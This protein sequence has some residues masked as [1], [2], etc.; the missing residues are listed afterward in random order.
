MINEVNWHQKMDSS[1]VV[2]VV[3]TYN[4]ADNLTTLVERLN[5]VFESNKL[6]ARILVVDDSS[7]DGTAEIARKLSKNY[8]VDLLVRKKKEGLGRAYIAGF[9][10]A[11]EMGADYIF[12]MDADLSHDPKYVPDFME[13]IKTFD[14]VVGNRYIEGGETVDWPFH[15][16]L[17]SKSANILIKLVANLNIADVT[18]GYRVY[19]RAVLEEINFEKVM[20]DGYEFQF[21]MLFRAKQNNR[22]IGSVPIAFASRK[23]GETKLSKRDMANFFLRAFQMRLGFYEV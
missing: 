10:R 12:E 13:K 15:R 14:L 11:L 22:K 4:E 5:E 18:S 9:K 21:E 1:R 23:K 8:P 17:I 2:F 3:P 16:K 7:P 6:K 19:K 20:S